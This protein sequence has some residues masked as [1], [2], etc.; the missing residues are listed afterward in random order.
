MH[1]CRSCCYRELTTVAQDCSGSVGEG[2]VDGW[3][4][5]YG[6][7]GGLREEG[8]HF[9]HHQEDSKLDFLVLPSI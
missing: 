5:S 1:R 3:L 7:K 6:R 4:G 9:P 8:F 2:V